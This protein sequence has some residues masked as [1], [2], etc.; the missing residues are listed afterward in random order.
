MSAEKCRHNSYPTIFIGGA[1]L[2]C[3]EIV[4][5]SQTSFF[6]NHIKTIACLCL[7]CRSAIVTH[8]IQPGNCHLCKY[9][10]VCTSRSIHCSEDAPALCK[11]FTIAYSCSPKMKFFCP[12]SGKHQVRV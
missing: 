12:I 9:F 3:I 11:Q 2:Q 1:G 10:S 7:D 4:E 8:G 5:N 6:G